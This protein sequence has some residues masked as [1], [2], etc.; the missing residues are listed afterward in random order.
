MSNQPQT[1]NRVD[2][3]DPIQTWLEN[4][5]KVSRVIAALIIPAALAVVG[6]VEHL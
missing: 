6:I 5:P 2:F 1:E 4:H 3:L